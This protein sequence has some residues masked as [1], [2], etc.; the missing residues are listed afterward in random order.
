LNVVL[1]NQRL[2]LPEVVKEINALSAAL[3]EKN[4]A[5]Q[6]YSQDVVKALMGLKT[7]ETLRINCGGKTYNAPSG[8]TW[9]TDVFFSGGVA[10]GAAPE[11]LPEDISGTEDDVIYSSRRAFPLWDPSGKSYQIPVIPG[12]LY[13][14]LHTLQGHQTNG[15]A[16]T[17]SV[18]AERKTVVEDY[19]FRSVGVA[20]PDRISFP[21]LRSDAVLDIEFLP[22]LVGAHVCAIEVSPNP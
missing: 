4:P 19:S 16:F 14:T 5:F 21:V 8:E 12:N 13:V 9:R 17:F 3:S 10:G 7:G 15:E 1:L 11:S 18:K 20:T 22:S 6:S 2:E